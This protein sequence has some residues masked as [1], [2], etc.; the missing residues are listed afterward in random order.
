MTYRGIDVSRIRICIPYQGNIGYCSFSKYL[1]T[2]ITYMKKERTTKETKTYL[3]LSYS[4]TKR[5]AEM[6]FW[7]KL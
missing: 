5:A 3:E 4:H 2:R 6:P 1:P 7:H